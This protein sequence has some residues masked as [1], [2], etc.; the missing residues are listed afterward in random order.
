MQSRRP[1]SQDFDQPPAQ[2]RTAAGRCDHQGA[3][4]AKPRRFIG[5]ARDRARSEHD[6]LALD[7]MNE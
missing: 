6:A 7:I 5:K 2:A 1:R 3:V 4:Q